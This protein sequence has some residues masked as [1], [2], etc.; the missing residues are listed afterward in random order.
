MFEQQGPTTVVSTSTLLHAT[1][2]WDAGPGPLYRRLAQAIA[3]AVERGDLP[4]RARLPSERQLAVRLS[5]ARGTVVG[6]YEVLADAGILE[7]RQ[8]SGTWVV[9]PAAGRTIPEFEAGV[10]SRNLT[11]RFLDAPGDV[12]ELAPCVIHSPEGLPVAAFEQD[13]TAMAR[14]ANGHGYHPLGLPALRQGLAD[15]HTRQGLPTDVSQI[16]VTLGGQQA[17]AVTARLLVERGDPVVVESAT[18]P[19]A[20]DAYSR[21]GAHFETVPTDSGGARPDDLARAVERSSAALVYLVPTCHNPTGV[22]MPAVR[23]RDVARLSDATGTWIVEDESL[24]WAV[25]DRHEP[26]RPIAG[27]A[28]GSHV[29]SIGS[30]SKLFWGGL[31]IGWIRADANLIAKVG[32]L[33][34]AEDLGNCTISQAIALALLRDIDQIADRRREQIRSGAEHLAGLLAA[35]LPDWSFVPPDGGLSLWVRLPVG[36]GDGFTT[37]AR[38]HGVSVLPGSSASAREDHLDHIRISCTQPHHL[39]T[40]GVA[41][42]AQAWR[43]YRRTLEGTSP[44]AI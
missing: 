33:K 4:R 17:I 2:N 28:T 37:V 31:R 44:A 7:R 43:A 20:I 27:Y 42:L 30:L 9:D 23:R 12:I 26:P 32:R 41:R 11:D 36:W 40:E 39:L 22:V 8:G 16:A 35:H 21:A 3:T 34:A 13:V 24:G 25:F 10:R 15:L 14:L 29:I 1:P 6:A 38:A 18:F 19:G 5:V